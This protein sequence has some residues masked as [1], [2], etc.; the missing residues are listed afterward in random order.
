MSFDREPLVK[1]TWLELVP[2][3][4]YRTFTLGCR[5]HRTAQ[6]L[7]QRLMYRGMTEVTIG[8]QPAV[9]DLQLVLVR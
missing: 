6:D 9:G 3:G 2:A 7:A 8:G 1:V 4:F 5:D